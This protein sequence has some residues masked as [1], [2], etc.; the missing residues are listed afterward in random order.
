MYSVYVIIMM[1]LFQEAASKIR[2]TIPY[3]RKTPISCKNCVHFLP[4]EA[5]YPFFDVSAVDHCKKFALV[6]S[7]PGNVTYVNAFQERATG[8]CGPNATH[9]QARYDFSIIAN[10]NRSTPLKVIFS[11]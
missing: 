5:V 1:N 3:I 2:Q 11:Y 8:T 7:T 10:D 9:F 6:G 4:K